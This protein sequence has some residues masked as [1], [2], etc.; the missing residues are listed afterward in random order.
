VRIEETD[1]DFRL[2]IDGLA[3]ATAPAAA[4]LEPAVVR[5]L[6]NVV[7]QRLHGLSAIHAGAVVWQGQALLLPG[8]SHSGKSTLVAELVRA[9]ATYF[10]DEYA[11]IDSEGQVHA[12]PRPMLLR[13]AKPDAVT[14]PVEKPGTAPAS[15]RWILALRYEP[16]CIWNPVAADQAQGVLMLLRNTPHILATMPGIVSS[17]ERAVAGAQ[18]LTGCRPEAADAADE[19]LRLIR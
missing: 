15:V 10:S 7:V 18:C 4:T 6:D 8:S 3:F 12:Y 1:H 9:G 17:F 11:L 5:I 2:L 16:G 19:I 14:S 13:N